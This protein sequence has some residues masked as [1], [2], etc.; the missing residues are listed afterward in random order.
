MDHVFG[1]RKKLRKLWVEHV[2]LPGCSRD[3]GKVHA[4]GMTA[5]CPLLPIANCRFQGEI[6][7]HGVIC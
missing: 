7:V 5:L 4:P 6:A 2:V 1:V 3:A